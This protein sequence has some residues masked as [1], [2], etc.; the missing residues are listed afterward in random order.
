MTAVR[1]QFIQ[2]KFPKNV[3][4]GPSVTLTFELASLKVN[5]P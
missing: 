5:L 3:F 1:P 4:Y 2:K